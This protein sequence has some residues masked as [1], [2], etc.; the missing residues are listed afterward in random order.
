MKKDDLWILVEVDDV[1][2]LIEDSII[3]LNLIKASKYLGPIKKEVESWDL[4]LCQML[5]TIRTWYRFQQR[6][7]ELEAIFSS[8]DIRHDLA[9]IFRDFKHVDKSFHE[10]SLKYISSREVN[11]MKIATS[12]GILESFQSHIVQLERVS[13]SLDDYL[14]NKRTSFSR[15]YF[16]SREE[17]LEVIFNPSDTSIVNPYLSKLFGS[18]QQLQLISGYNPDVSNIHG[19]VSKEGEVLKLERLVPAKNTSSKWWIA[20]LMVS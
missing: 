12:P 17:L 1:L 14:D 6:W 19:V 2:A 18:V 20:N 11:A 16:L 4:S 7:S 9:L 15:F 5:A 13:R 10:F 8:V 3:N